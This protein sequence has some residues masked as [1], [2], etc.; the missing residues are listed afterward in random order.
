MSPQQTWPDLPS[1]A[2]FTD[3]YELTMLQAYVEEGLEDEAVFSLFVRRLPERRNYL[4]ACGLADVLR[5]LE[6]LA[7]D[8]RA[9]AYLDSLGRFSGRFLQYLA[10]LRFT[11]HV[12]AVAEGTPI[13]ADE[14][15][16][17]IAAPMP[18]AQLVETIVMN[19][20]TL[21]TV[22]ASKAVRVVTAARGRSV[23]DFGVRRMHGID[24]GLKA[25]RA[26]HIAGLEGTSHVAAGQL[27][28]I[29]V[30]GTMAH[31]YIQAHDDELEAFRRFSS[32]YPDTVLLVD[33]YD[34][35]EGIR[36]VIRLAREVGSAFRVRA[37]RL[38]SGDLLALSQEAR[39]LLDDAGLHHVQILAS[40]G[41]DEDA[42]SHLLAQEAPIDGF[43][44]GTDLGVSRDAPSLDIAYKL[45]SYAGEGRIKLSPGKPVL[46]GRKQVYRIEEGGRAVRDVISEA[47]QSHQGRPLLRSVMKDGRRLPEG[48]VSLDTARALARE[49]MDRL[50]DRLRGLE[51]ADPPYLVEV[52]ADLRAWHDRLEA[53]WRPAERP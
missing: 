23:I 31:S 26:F 37:V 17:E 40:G 47:H 5:Y 7:F 18:Q 33:T 13:F 43:G 11:G 14:P 4:L 36:N 52:S 34:T 50:P 41:L 25:A 39:R 35:L 48:E 46:P 29:P 21:Q 9:L 45:V 24:A 49:E 44:V 16:L 8:A 38:D 19:Q 53:R 28:G 12:Y 10:E 3:L 15:I 32:L 22:L 27:Y 30:A 1:P 51:P 20:I 42:I 6:T 2:L